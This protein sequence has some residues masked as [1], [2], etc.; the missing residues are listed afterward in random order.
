MKI[1]IFNKIHSLIKLKKDFFLLTNVLNHTQYVFEEN[2]LNIIPEDINLS[3]LEKK[4]KSRQNGMLNEVWFIKFFSQKIKVI[5]NGAVHITQALAPMCRICNYDVII[6]DPRNIFA[7]SKRFP[8]ENI[9][10]TWSNDYLIKNPLD[11]HTAVVTLTH[12]PK[13]DDPI[14]KLALEQKCFYI[15][16]LGSIK[17]HKARKERLRKFG[18]SDNDLDNLNGPAGLDIN[19]KSPEEIAVSILA[20]LIMFTRMKK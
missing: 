11:K 2:D 19:A 8:E 7:N 5:I 10:N 16:C 6:L 4:I 13:I 18:F 9:I 17:T 12:D 14:I 20:E 3:D 15:S 1:K